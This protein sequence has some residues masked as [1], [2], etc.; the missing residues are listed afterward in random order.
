[1]RTLPPLPMPLVRSR[2]RPPTAGEGKVS[3]FAMGRR[4][5]EARGDAIGPADAVVDDVLIN[6]RLGV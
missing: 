5:G 4:P 3:F 6:A 1:M 2:L